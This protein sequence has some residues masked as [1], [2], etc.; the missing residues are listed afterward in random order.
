MGKSVF[1]QRNDCCKNFKSCNRTD[2]IGMM[3]ILPIVN[4][5]AASLLIS[6]SSPQFLLRIPMWWKAVCSNRKCMIFQQPLLPHS[7]LQAV[8]GKAGGWEEQWVLGYPKEDS[9]LSSFYLHYLHFIAWNSWEPLWSYFFLQL[10]CWLTKRTFD[11]YIWSRM[12]IEF[13]KNWI[14][15]YITLNKLMRTL[16]SLS[17]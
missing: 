9:M 17:H 13:D 3:D 15:D 6:S 7:D 8:E 14:Y 4:L 5:W 1:F 2:M 11:V 16:H 10:P 12:L